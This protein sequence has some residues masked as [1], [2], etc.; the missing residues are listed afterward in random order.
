MTIREGGTN[1]WL[2]DSVMTFGCISDLG[3]SPLT[4][5]I[6]VN[7]WVDGNGSGDVQRIPLTLVTQS[8]CV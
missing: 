3:C 1:G 2:V 7:R 8:S 5:D 6:D 4:Q